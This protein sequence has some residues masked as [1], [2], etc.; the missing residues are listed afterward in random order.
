MKKNLIII[1]IDGGRL[2]YASKSE[3][4]SNIK[5]KSVFLSQSITYGPHTIAAMHA[6]FSGCYGS[7][8]GTNSYWSTYKFKKN[9]FKTLTEYLHE[10]NFYTHA[11]V[12]NKL[13]VP[14]QGF[15]EFHIHDEEK[16]DLT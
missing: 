7:R 12:I 3:I 15:D 14:K 4:F 5:S 10:H 11:D 8:T 13:I 16:D 6:V 1:M 2:D 9:Q